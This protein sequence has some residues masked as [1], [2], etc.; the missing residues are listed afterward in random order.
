MTVDLFI[1]WLLLIHEFRLHIILMN[2]SFDNTEIAFAY[3]TDKELKKAR[4]LF[5][6]MGIAWLVKLGTKIT[7]W[8]IKANFLLTELIRNTFL[9]NL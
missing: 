7:P 4:F 5:S 9:N 1:W 8:A 6:T 3:K 2:I